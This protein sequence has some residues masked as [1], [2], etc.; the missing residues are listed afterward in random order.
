MYRGV[1]AACM[2]QGVACHECEHT[3]DIMPP[4]KLTLS[5]WSN[6]KLCTAPELVTEFGSHEH[7]IQ[8]DE[9]YWP[10]RAAYPQLYR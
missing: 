1:R 10:S 5:R 3:F 8:M 9:R 2:R 6:V 4:G 7:L